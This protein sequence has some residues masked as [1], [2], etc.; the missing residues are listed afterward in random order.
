[1][2]GANKSRSA[3]KPLGYIAA[4][5]WITAVAYHTWTRWP[6]VPLD[7]RPDAPEVSQAYERAVV[8]HKVQAGALALIPPALAFSLWTL[9]FGKRRDDN[10][11]PF[12]PA[13]I[14]LMR[15]AEKTGDPSD[16]HLS[17]EGQRRAERLATYI[18][19]TF[20][21]PDF[22]FAAAR[23]KRSLRSIETMAPLAAATGVP[24]DSSID[25]DN[26]EDLVEM[27][28]ND[29]RYAGKLVVVCWHHSDLPKIARALGAADGTYPDPWGDSVFDQIIDLQRQPN[30]TP[31]VEL[32]VQPF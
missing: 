4:T 30:G 18:P 14:L 9:L 21:K 1:M 32:I 19:Q 3:S 25:D 2:S 29:P 5:L 8:R 27:L 22:I 12:G 7:M 28:R 11:A 13:R 17:P 26:Y 20:G 10:S 24:L 23:S 31:A 16:L 6:A 15:H